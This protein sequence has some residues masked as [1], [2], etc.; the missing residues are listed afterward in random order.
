VPIIALMRLIAGRKEGG[1]TKWLRLSPSS[2]CVVADALQH[3]AQLH[4][5]RGTR[6]QKKSNITT[7]KLDRT[8]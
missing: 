4:G 2:T 3:E 7:L 8:S 6:D 5:H 1:K